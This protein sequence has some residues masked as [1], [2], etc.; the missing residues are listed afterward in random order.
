MARSF[1][2]DRILRAH[3]HAGADVCPQCGIRN[4]GAGGFSTR[5]RL[6][7]HVIYGGRFNVRE[8][9]CHYPDKSQSSTAK[10]EEHPMKRV[11]FT[12]I[13]LCCLSSPAFSQMT[14][15]DLGSYCSAISETST[16]ILVARTQGMPRSQAEALMQGMTDPVAIRL[17]KEALDF[18]YSRPARATVDGLRAE[19]RNMCLGPV[20]K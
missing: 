12:I 8:L 16:T 4:P 17:I 5:A 1:L 11:L 10:G 15:T 9:A 18:A 3:Q 14:F 2:A 19:L 6:D 13:S 7:F 20:H